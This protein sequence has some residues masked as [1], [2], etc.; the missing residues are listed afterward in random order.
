MPFIIL[1]PPTQQQAS[2]PAGKVRQWVAQGEALGTVLQPGV[3][4]CSQ[5]MA[6]SCQPCAALLTYPNY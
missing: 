2:S 1:I 3:S 4:Q 6:P 5:S